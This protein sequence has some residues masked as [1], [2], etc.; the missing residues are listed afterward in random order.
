MNARFWLIPLFF[1]LICVGLAFLTGA[2]FTQVRSAKLEQSSLKKSIKREN[3]LYLKQI[4][5]QLDSLITESENIQNTKQI[6][7]DSPFFA[8]VI[9][10]AFENEQVYTHNE[11]LPLHL[12]DQAQITDI[13]EKGGTEEIKD[14]AEH[15]ANDTELVEKKKL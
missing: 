10:H 6:S 4:S 11:S 15:I 9:L 8:L 5:D 13:F 1:V 12:K 7:A 3:S 2:S 14:S